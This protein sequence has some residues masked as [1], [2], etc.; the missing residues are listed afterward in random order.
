MVGVIQHREG[1][2]PSS[3]RKSPGQIEFTPIALERGVTREPNSRTG[4]T[5]SGAS[6]PGAARK[7]L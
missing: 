7:S 3:T 6:V 2:D 4:L 5:K 1:G